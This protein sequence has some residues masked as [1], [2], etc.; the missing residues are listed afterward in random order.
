VPPWMVSVG[1]LPFRNSV[2][3]TTPTTTTCSSTS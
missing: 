1:M 2:P 3:V